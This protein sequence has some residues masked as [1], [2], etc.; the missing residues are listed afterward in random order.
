MKRDMLLVNFLED[1]LEDTRELEEQRVII[2]YGKWNL[3][4]TRF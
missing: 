2:F 3:I 1:K 4:Y